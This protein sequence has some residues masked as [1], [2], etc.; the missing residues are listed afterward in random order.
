MMNSLLSSPC[1]V[2]GIV[3]A[4]F[5]ARQVTLLSTTVFVFASPFVFVYLE[6]HQVSNVQVHQHLKY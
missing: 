2:Y 5:G 3:R 4:V 1:Y 6:I